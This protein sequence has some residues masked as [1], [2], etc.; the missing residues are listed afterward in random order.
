MLH[1]IPWS[2]VQRMMID[3]PGYDLDDGKE[4][5]IQLSEDNS[6]QIMNYI[7]SMM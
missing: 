1:G 4:T 3:A 6:E 5:E 7:N 2:V